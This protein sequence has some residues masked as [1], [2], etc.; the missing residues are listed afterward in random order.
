MANYCQH[1]FLQPGVTTHNQAWLGNGQAPRIGNNLLRKEIFVRNVG[2]AWINM[3]GGQL[4]TLGKRRK[5]GRSPETP[6]WEPGERSDNAWLYPQT[7]RGTLSQAL[8]GH[9]WQYSDS[10]TC[11]TC[12][13]FTICIARFSYIIVLDSWHSFMSCIFSYISA[14]LS[15][16]WLLP[17]CAMFLSLWYLLSTWCKQD[18]QILGSCLSV[19]LLIAVCPL[20]ESINSKHVVYPS[21]LYLYGSGRNQFQWYFVANMYS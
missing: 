18:P 12:K 4:H 20:L 1:C 16:R 17:L 2:L 6:Q 10:G 5:G 9:K 13:L 21:T 19:N 7:C 8:H 15:L 3:E 11:I 14:S